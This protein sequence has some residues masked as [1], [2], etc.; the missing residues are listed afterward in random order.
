MRI[1]YICTDFGIPVHGTKGASIHVRELSRALHDLGH[2]VE[3]FAA[4]AGGDPPSGFAVPVHELG[5]EAPERRVY[6]MLRDDPAGGE[7]VAKEFR[8]SLHVTSFRHRALDRIRASAPD[9]IYERHALLG[10]AGGAL[11]R[12]LGIPHILE[13]NAPLSQEQ[14]DHRGLTFGQTARALERAILI[15]ADHV[16][17]VSAPLERWLTS[18]GVEPM[19]I[20]VLPNAVD[21]ER[22]AA[23]ASQPMASRAEL[24]LPEDRPVV[25]FLGTL[26]AWHG[27]ATLI[28]AVARLHR[29]GIRPHLLIVGDGPER[30]ALRVRA[31]DAGIVSATTFTGA[32]PYAEIPGLLAAMDIAVA[33]YDRDEDAYFSPL[34]L[35]EY[36]AA[37]RP[38]VAA[39]TGPIR[40]CMTH[41]E[42]G[43]LYPPGDV[44][45]LASSIGSLLAEP[46]RA[47]ALGRAGQAYVHDHHT[48]EQN[49]RAVTE[50]ISA[51]PAVI[52]G[53]N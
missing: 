1:A 15:A 48:W 7:E 18:V 29:E 24:G 37:G 39:A 9:A 25:G 3:I 49:A 46:A 28:D 27:T 47:A 17:A 11:A 6:E 14:A 42:T 26:K 40:S 21:A 43:L 51:A 32:M 35:F 19:R 13:V 30:D 4:R 33:P 38:T 16:I 45:A 8:A 10:T 34:K 20:T 53:T 41:G 31:R 5:L 2:Q 36:L 12:E 50:I 52:G 22:F 44:V 23:G